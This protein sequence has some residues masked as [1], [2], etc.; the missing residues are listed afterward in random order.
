V[1][2]AVPPERKLAV[3]SS[4]DEVPRR[5]RTVGEMMDHDDSEAP[6]EV[7]VDDAGAGI[8]PKRF[9]RSTAEWV[10]SFGCVP[11][12]RPY[13]A[14]IWNCALVSAGCR[15]IGRF[16][17][18]S[19][20]GRGVA[21]EC[22]KGLLNHCGL[23][24]V[25]PGHFIEPLVWRDL[26]K[27]LFSCR[28][29]AAKVLWDTGEETASEASVVAAVVAAWTFRSAQDLLRATAFWRGRSIERCLGIEL[30]DSIQAHAVAQAGPGGLDRLTRQYYAYHRCSLQ[31]RCAAVSPVTFGFPRCQ[32]LLCHQHC[33]CKTAVRC[34]KARC[35]GRCICRDELV[36]AATTMEVDVFLGTL[37]LQLSMVLV[38]AAVDGGFAPELTASCWVQGDR[39]PEAQVHPN[40]LRVHLWAVCVDSAG[41]SFLTAIGGRQRSDGSWRW[42]HGYDVLELQGDALGMSDSSSVSPAEC[43]RA[44]VFVR[45]QVGLG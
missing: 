5:T 17:A 36:S 30:L 14:E 3:P 8:E 10:Q 29:A 1:A 35:S 7:I 2:E 45:V 22:W 11:P 41:G 4:T 16:A 25:F 9:I 44:L 38:F 37:S 26:C 12:S 40:G 39:S 19:R 32:G 15:G 33:V 13:S 42:K 23:V 34:R 28:A 20:S 18:A 6:T 21:D 31:W 43:V 27:S 24:H